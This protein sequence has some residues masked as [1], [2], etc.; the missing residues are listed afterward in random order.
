MLLLMCVTCLVWSQIGNLP[1]L[2]NSAQTRGIAK[3]SGFAE[4]LYRNRGYLIN[5]GGSRIPREQAHVR[6]S[7]PPENRQ[8]SGLH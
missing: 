7:S 8:R 5:V 4:A 6:K 1:H 3:I 2:I